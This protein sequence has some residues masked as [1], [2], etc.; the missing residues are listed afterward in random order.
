MREREVLP[1]AFKIRFLSGC[2]RDF[3]SPRH[4]LLLSHA[5]KSPESVTKVKKPKTATKTREPR[6]SRSGT[7]TVM[8]AMMLVCVCV[9]VCGGGASRG[10]GHDAG[11]VGVRGW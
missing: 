2:W 8:R 5:L 7:A 11:G 3:S 6:Y 4:S 1:L 10:E 9:C